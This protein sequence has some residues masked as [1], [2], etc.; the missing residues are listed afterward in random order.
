MALVVY[1]VAGAEVYLRTKCHLDPSRH[2]AAI[3]MGRKLGGERLVSPFLDNGPHLT[4]RG[5]G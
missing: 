2:L 3:D 5:L 4:Q 1:N